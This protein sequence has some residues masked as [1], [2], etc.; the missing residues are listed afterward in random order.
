MEVEINFPKVYEEVVKHIIARDRRYIVLE[1]GRAGGKTKNISKALVLLCMQQ[2]VLICAGREFSNS[3]SDS[4]HKAFE[5]AILEDNFPGWDIQ[6]ERIKYQNGSEI[7]FKGLR[8]SESKG[9]VDAQRIKGLEGVDI[10]WGEE[11]QSFSA[12]ALEVLI[13]TIRKEKSMIIFTANRLSMHD[14][15]RARLVEPLV[16]TENLPDAKPFDDGRT[17]IQKIN[18]WDIEGYLNKETIEERDRFKVLDPEA[19]RHV[20]EGEP[21][22]EQS[23]GIF[24]RQL[25]E[26]RNQSR[27]GAYPYVSNHDVYAAF[28]LGVSDSTAIWLYQVIE[29]AVHFIDYI[30]DF[31]RPIANYFMDLK[32][33]GYHYGTIYLPH[34]ANARSNRSGD[35]DQVE[36][37]TLLEDLQKMLPEFRFKVLPRNQAYRGID[38]ARGMFSTF[39]FDAKACELGLQR[40]AGYRYD[41]SVKNGIW[42]QHP[43][44][45]ENSHGADAFQ[46]AVMAIEDIR[47]S[48]KE[49]SGFT[50]KTYVPKEFSNY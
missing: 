30:E 16:G 29:G 3:T 46:Y 6:S 14:P 33:K 2:K 34:D 45:D 19:F 22:T 37:T 21:L 31:G 11:A 38:M 35:L 1:S 25:A 4:V 32:D 12:E 26:C 7:I 39:Y 44:H 15:Y 27:I 36:A 48:A 23:G 5:D 50:F 10:F 40:L 20:W 18:S 47:N 43:K 9:T 13:P 17:F 28:D 8:T 41:Y 49:E 42:S 24:S